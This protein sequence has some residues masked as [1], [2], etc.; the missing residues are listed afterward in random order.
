VPAS[1]FLGTTLAPEAIVALFGAGLATETRTADTQPL[2]T[3]LAGTRVVVIDARGTARFAPL[4]FVAPGQINFLIP[5][6]TANGT[7]TVQVLASS[8]VPVSDGRVT[9]AASAPGLFA[10]NANGQ[11]VAAAVALRVKADGTQVFEAIARFDQAQNR[12][13]PVPIDLGP[14]TEKVFLILYGS[15]I[16]GRTALSAVNLRLGDV[17][18]PVSFAGGVPGL[19][20]LDQINAELPRALIGRGDLSTSLSIDGRTANAVGVNIK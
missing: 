9:I 2:P 6:G 16:R 4:F 15:G 7:A 5:V 10:A 14:E 19:T 1:S 11:G 8:A 18:L 13:V 12:F 3:E 17:S 20:G